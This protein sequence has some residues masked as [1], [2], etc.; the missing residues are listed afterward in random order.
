VLFIRAEVNLLPGETGFY[1]VA[2]TIALLCAFRPR[3][4]LGAAIFVALAAIALVVVV[5]G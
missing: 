1:L 3:G 4:L 5:E 2:G